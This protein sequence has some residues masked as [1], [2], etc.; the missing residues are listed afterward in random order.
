MNTDVAG[1]LTV[2]SGTLKIS[3][4]FTMTNRTFAVAGYAIPAAGGFWL[5]NPNY[6]VAGQNGN[7]TV[8]GLFR[9]TQGTY[10]VGTASNNVLALASN[11]T[12]IVEGGT[13]TA[14][15]RL[16]VSAAGNTVN[17]TQTGG[18][19]TV[20]TIGNTSTTL[21]NFD[22]GTS[23]GSLVSM[24]GGT[25]IIRLHSS[26]I[27][28][29]FDADPSNLTGTTVQLGDASSG[30]AKAFSLRGV[31]PNLVISNT[32]ANHTATFNNTLVN[33]Y[34]V[35]T[36]NVTINTGNTLS[37]AGDATSV[38]TFFEGNILNNGTLNASNTNMSVEMVA[39]GLQSYSG[40]GTMTAP[41]TVM[42]IDGGGVDFTGA[43]NQQVISRINLYTGSLAGANKITLGNG[44]ATSAFIQIGNGGPPALTTGP[45]TGT[46]VNN[47]GSGGYNIFYGDVDA[48]RSTGGEIPAG[49]TVTNATFDSEGPNV[50]IAGG[51]LTVTGTT[52][53]GDPA[54]TASN[55]RVITGANNLIIGSAGTVTRVGGLGHVDGNLV[56]NFATNTALTF[57]SGTANGYSPVM[58]NMTAGAP[59]P[60]TV[61]STQMVQPN[62]PN[63][64]MALQRYWTFT[65]SG[66]TADLT[67]N[68]LDPTDIPGTANENNFV[69][70][71]YDG[72]SLTMPGGSVNTVA[73]TATITGVT[74]FSD[75][76]LAEPAPTAPALASAVSRL[77]THTGVGAFDVNMPLKRNQWGGRSPDQHLQHCPHP[78]PMA[79][80][81]PARQQ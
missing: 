55:G 36:G 24:S 22:L 70:F 8:T 49:R 37:L 38:L 16:A 33:F 57:E 5:N 40:T 73:N 59:A 29:R 81:L 12:T 30:A 19:I 47:A 21:G 50:T 51:D 77:P 18:I 42:E 64:T 26:G 25:I 7:G 68:Y 2:T 62:I 61:K 54:D 39:T 32:S 75:W 35:I 65:A 9:L 78:L 46:I 17:Y 10:N 43:V 67:F 56:K 6:T 52:T 23:A 27:D 58:V 69:I 45:V 13:L 63:P 20:C 53:F 15:S 66:V 79:R 4:T 76:T 72:V 60:F 48:D 80:L 44:G 74:S 71:K 28:Y 34:H 14:A 1:F 31:L 41:T 11:S 3:G